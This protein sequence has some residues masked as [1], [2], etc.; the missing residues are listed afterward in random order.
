M[1]FGKI[2]AKF[3]RIGKKLRKSFGK[4]LELKKLLGKLLRLQKIR[5][6]LEKFWTSDKKSEKVQEK[7][8]SSVKIQKKF[9]KSRNEHLWPINIQIGNNLR[10]M[11][12]YGLK[13]TYLCPNIYAVRRSSQKNYQDNLKRPS[14]EDQEVAKYSKNKKLASAGKQFS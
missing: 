3:G 6:N 2:L 12:S 13:M 5:K 14:R 7:V 1:L 11:I 4:K 9:L 8:R 10:E